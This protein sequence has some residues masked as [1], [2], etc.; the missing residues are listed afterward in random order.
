MIKVTHICNNYVSSKVHME[1]VQAIGNK[2]GYTQFVYVPVRSRDHIGLNYIEDVNLD[3]FNYHFNF[4]RFFPL[5]KVLI[6]FFGFFFSKNRSNT[7][8]LIAHNFWSDGMVAFLNYI[9]FKEP[10]VLVVRNTD[11]NIF[12]PKLKHYHW[13]MSLMVEKSEGLIFVNKIYK[14]KFEKE[15]NNIY[16]KSKNNHLIFNGVNNFWLEKSEFITNKIQDTLIYVGGF[17]D[18]KNIKSIIQACNK[19]YLRRPKLKLILVGGNE[20]ELRNLLDQKEIPEY[21]D[22]LGKIKDKE[23]LLEFYKNSKV[24]IMPSFFETFGLVYIE[25]LMQGCSIIHSKGQGIDGIFNEDFIQAVDPYDVNDIGEKIDFLL[26]NFDKRKSDIE[27]YY[28]LSVLFNWN[29]IADQYLRV[30]NK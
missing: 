14:D 30:I 10:Y 4:L 25:A 13:L 22:V 12:I 20:K 5:I 24:F 3:Y 8:I 18:N 15:Y 1:L 29:S 19:I 17:N 23:Q 6:V 2:R 21:V 26:E 7:D 16:R 27:F 28:N 9:F 11:I